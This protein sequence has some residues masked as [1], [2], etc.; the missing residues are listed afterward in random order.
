WRNFASSAARSAAPTFAGRPS[1]LWPLSTAK[2]THAAR[3]APDGDEWLPSA[4]YRSSAGRSFVESSH[5][6]PTG[7]TIAPR[8][9]PRPE[10]AFTRYACDCGQLAFAQVMK[11][12]VLAPSFSTSICRSR[13]YLFVSDRATIGLVLCSCST[14]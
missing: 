2:S 10:Y 7:A 6:S 11:K 13:A 4:A 3:Y 14:T 5:A 9:R 1:G 8:L 12:T